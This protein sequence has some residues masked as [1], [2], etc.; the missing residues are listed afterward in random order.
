MAVLQFRSNRRQT[1]GIEIELGLVDAR[2]MGLS[3]SYAKLAEVLPDNGRQ[4]FKPELLQSVLEINTEICESVKDAETELR[5]RLG[6]VEAATDGLGL[7]LWWGGIHPFSMCRDQR[8][9]PDDRYVKLVDLLIAQ[10]E[11]LPEGTT[12]PGGVQQLVEVLCACAER[13]LVAAGER[14]R[15]HLRAAV[16]R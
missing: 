5:G 7:A 2:S 15:G 14:L 3:N 16:G 12:P 1:L 11:A 4:R 8:V 6:V 10:R 9:T 13:P